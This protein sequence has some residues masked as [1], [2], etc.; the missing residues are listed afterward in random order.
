MTVVALLEGFQKTSHLIGYKSISRQHTYTEIYQR[1][2]YFEEQVHALVRGSYFLFKGSY[3]F[4]DLCLMLAL[5]KKNKILVILDKDKVGNEGERVLA[6]ELQTQ[7]TIYI[8]DGKAQC[9]ATKPQCLPLLVQSLTEIKEP[10]MCILTTGSS[11]TPKAALYNFNTWLARFDGPG[12]SLT[13]PLLLKFDHLGGLQTLFYMWCNMGCPIEL[14]S[15]NPIDVLRR[16]EE[17]SADFF[18]VT[19]SFLALLILQVEEVV[20]PNIKI[21]SFGAEPMPEPLISR[22][23]EIF[24]NARLIQ[25]YGL[26]ETGTLKTYTSEDPLFIKFDKKIN[27]V[28]IS[29][30]LLEVKSPYMMLGYLNASSPFTKDGWLQTG[31]QVIQKGDSFRIL[32]RASDMINVGGE[33]VSP[34][35]VEEVLLSHPEISNAYVFSEPHPLLG[36]IVIAEVCTSLSKDAE[37]SIKEFCLDK[38]NRYKIPVKFRFQK[39]WKLHSSLKKNSVRPK[40]E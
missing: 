17:T 37:V 23:N 26:S 4:D 22:V 6:K 12:R 36:Q 10:G 35:E 30:G 15:R 8:E 7:G 32:G 27:Q 25:T 18:A 11:G 1:V 5:F 24:P 38:L 34:L 31:D 28:R 40:H 20:Y 9:R 39:E 33:K 2:V 19:P 13:S 3:S 16:L 21:L 14:T 29:N